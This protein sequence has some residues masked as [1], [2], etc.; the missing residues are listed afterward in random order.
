[1]KRYVK[2]GYEIL[3]LDDSIDEFVFQHVTEYEKRKV[4]SIA[5][6]DLNILDSTEIAKKKT[7]KLKDMYKP[8]ITYFK[9]HLGEQV[10]KVQVSS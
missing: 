7:A 2:E 9:N 4:K 6:D 8:L 1:M 5:K 3:V 10:S